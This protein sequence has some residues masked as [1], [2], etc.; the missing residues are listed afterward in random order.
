MVDVG[1]SATKWALFVQILIWTSPSSSKSN[2]CFPYLHMWC[3]NSR[4]HRVTMSGL[5]GKTDFF[6]LMRSFCLPFSSMWCSSCCEPSTGSYLTSLNRWSWRSRGSATW[7]SRLWLKTRRL[8]WWVEAEGPPLPPQ[9]PP[10]QVSGT[11][12]VHTHTQC[13]THF[14]HKTQHSSSVI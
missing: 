13:H 11:W 1:L 14:I 5:T 3:P 8:C 10:A 9:A 7:P 12:D 4:V 6:T 2:C